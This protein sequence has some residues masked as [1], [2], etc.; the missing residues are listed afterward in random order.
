MQNESIFNINH[1]GISR[2]SFD[3]YDDVGVGFGGSQLGMD[4]VRLSLDGSTNTNRDDERVGVER[5]ISVTSPAESG[6][7]LNRKED[8]MK[9]ALAVALA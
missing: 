5:R 4:F 9:S 6:G 3:N 7:T 2:S 8:A 1:I